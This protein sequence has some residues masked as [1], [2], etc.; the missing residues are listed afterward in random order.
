M[1]RSVTTLRG[2]GVDHKHMALELANAVTCRKSEV[3]YYMAPE[4]LVPE[5]FGLKPEN[6][7]PSKES[8]VYSLAM[9]AYEVNSSQTAH[10]YH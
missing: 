10:G 8:D 6:S 3:V 2:S 9:T 5:E 4:L 1:T 7:G